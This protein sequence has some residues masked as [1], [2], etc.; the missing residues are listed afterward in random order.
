MLYIQ[1]GTMKHENA[2]AWKMCKKSK[3]EFLVK[4]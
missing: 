2:K 4:K 1:E 3:I